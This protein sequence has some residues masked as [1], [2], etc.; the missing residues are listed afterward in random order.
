MSSAKPLAE[1]QPADPSIEPDRSD[2]VSA[3]AAATSGTALGERHGTPRLRVAGVEPRRG[4]RSRAR[5]RP[6]REDVGDLG[7]RR[8]FRDHGDGFPRALAGEP[9]AAAA[10]QQVQRLRRSGRARPARREHAR[11]R[12]APPTVNAHVPAQVV[13]H[14]P[15]W[16]SQHRGRRS[17]PP[18]R[19][20]R[21]A[22][23]ICGRT[24]IH[25]SDR[26]RR[27]DLNRA[28]LTIRRA[29]APR[30]SAGSGPRRPPPT[31]RGSRCRPPA[32]SRR[33]VRGR[34]G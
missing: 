29:G 18:R 26:P 9:R 32:G 34:G 8:H 23:A 7:D 20:A 12:A 25:R 10:T 24:A 5:R 30:R 13:P 19:R 6:P 15:P 16:G 11:H 28:P 3:S 31:A 21:A 22:G 2:T 17:R 27:R 1:R 33:P 14:Q 4:P